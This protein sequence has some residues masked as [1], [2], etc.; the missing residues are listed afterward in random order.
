MCLINALLSRPMLA[1]FGVHL[2]A[3]ADHLLAP[4]ATLGVVAGGSAI[5]GAI[6]GNVEAVDE[7]LSDTDGDA[8]IQRR[9][10]DGLIIGGSASLIPVALLVIE[11]LV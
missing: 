2:Q 9:Y 8:H 11:A 4:L 3:L 5:I 1:L 6:V 10:N 7:E